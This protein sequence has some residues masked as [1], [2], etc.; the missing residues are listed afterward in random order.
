MTVESAEEACARIEKE[1]G[2]DYIRY[3]VRRAHG[4]AVQI[5][6]GAGDSFDTEK[7]LAWLARR[8]GDIRTEAEARDKRRF[9]TLAAIGIAGIIVSALAAAGAAFLSN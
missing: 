4:V 1:R 9:C 2:L 8:E 7:V 5:E 6:P 3:A